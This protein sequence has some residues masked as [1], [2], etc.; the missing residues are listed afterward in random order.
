MLGRGGIKDFFKGRGESK[1]GGHYLKRGGDKYPLRTMSPMR[2]K[3]K[4]VGNN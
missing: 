1:K 3:F 4:L 2:G